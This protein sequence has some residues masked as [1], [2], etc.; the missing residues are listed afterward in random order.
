MVFSLMHAKNIC[1]NVH[2]HEYQS[3][4]SNKQLSK[5]KNDEKSI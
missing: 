1:T 5:R 4:D 2:S 3:F